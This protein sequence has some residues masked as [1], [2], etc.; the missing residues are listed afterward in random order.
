MRTHNRGSSSSS[1]FCC[2]ILWTVSSSSSSSR[3]S[4]GLAVA[5]RTL[6]R[7]RKIDLWII[8]SFF[9]LFFFTFLFFLI[10]AARLLFVYFSL[11]SCT[12]ASLWVN[13]VVM[14]VVAHTRTHRL[15]DFSLILSFLISNVMF[16]ISFFPP[17]L[18]DRCELC[19]S[20]R[21]WTKRRIIRIDDFVV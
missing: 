4:F 3:V 6:T 14:V 20:Q 2:C 8:V 16:L 18:F 10:V 5:P 1:F 13:Q 11:F 9:L 17:E 7:W 15:I 21:D 19:E 12:A